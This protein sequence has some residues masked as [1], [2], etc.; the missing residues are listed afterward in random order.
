MRDLGRVLDQRPLLAGFVGK[1]S[2]GLN[3]ASCGNDYAASAANCWKAVS[4]LA[5]NWPLQ[6]MCAVSISASVAAADVRDFN[7]SVGRVL[8][9][10]KRW[11]CSRML[12][13]YLSCRTSIVR[14]DPVILRTVS[15][16]LGLP[17][18]GP[19]FRR[20]PFRAG[21]CWLSCVGRS[22]ALR[23]DHGARTARNQGFG[24]HH[25]RPDK[26]RPL[27]SHSDVGFVHAP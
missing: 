16:P 15:P 8:R 6:I 17:N 9:L 12:L 2:L 4:P 5:W 23:P 24:H 25:L 14:P 27:A 20:P 7:P 18:W 11:S 13:R 19:F 21:H 22:V 10:M 26:D 3:E 1:I